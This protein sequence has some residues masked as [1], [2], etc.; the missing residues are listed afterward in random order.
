MDHLVEG[1]CLCSGDLYPGYY[2]E[3]GV[4]LAVEEIVLTL[5]YRY[6][7]GIMHCFYHLL[8]TMISASGDRANGAIL[9]AKRIR[10][11]VETRVQ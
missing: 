9:S 1:D 8:M 6:M 7:G 10:D 4:G 5:Q 3:S 11:H 2:C